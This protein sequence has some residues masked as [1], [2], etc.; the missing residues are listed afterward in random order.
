MARRERLDPLEERPRRPRAE[1][2]EEV[3]DPLRVGPRLDQPRGQQRLDL[4]APEQP[5][6]ALGVVERAD[7]HAVAAQD[8]RPVGAVPERDGELAP[9]LLE[10]PL[11][12]VLVEVDPGLGVA[13][14]RQP[15]AAGQQLLAQLGILEELAVEGDPDSS[16]PR[17]R[18]AAGRRPGR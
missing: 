12:A 5:A 18:S 2:R 8:Q 14:G 3:I 4:R 11:A 7:A 15:V 9:G 13:A 10:H 17:W 16:R 6:V 1:E